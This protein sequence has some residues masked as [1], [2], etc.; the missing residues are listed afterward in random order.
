M[1]RRTTFFQGVVVQEVTQHNN[2][3]Y[4]NIDCRFLWKDTY[5]CEYCA[6]SDDVQDYVPWSLIL[7]RSASPRYS[8]LVIVVRH[9]LRAHQLGHKDTSNKR[10][11]S[12][13]SARVLRSRGAAAGSRI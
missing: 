9:S 7:G 10:F 8:R 11:S 2:D 1:G 4:T 12:S 3:Y 6:S 13:D 5:P